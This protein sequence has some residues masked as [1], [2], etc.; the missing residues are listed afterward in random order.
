MRFAT[1]VASG[2]F[3]LPEISL[4]AD[5]M[6]MGCGPLAEGWDNPPQNRSVDTD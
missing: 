1:D 6:G 2:R 3:A 5:V 4:G